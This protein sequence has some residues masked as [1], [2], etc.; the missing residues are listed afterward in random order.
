MKCAGS[1]CGP[2]KSEHA[3]RGATI[4]LLSPQRI[5]TVGTQLGLRGTTSFKQGNDSSTLIKLSYISDMD[6]LEDKAEREKLTISITLATV[7]LQH[8]R[9][10]GPSTL[11]RH[12]DDILRILQHVATL[13]TT[14]TARNS[15][16]RKNDPNASRVVAVTA[17]VQDDAIRALLVT[18]N[19]KRGS[20]PGPTQETEIR[21]LGTKKA[22][23]E[24]LDR[25]YERECVLSNALIPIPHSRHM[26]NHC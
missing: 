8:H 25:W 24:V 16:D 4:F 6:S 20:S 26:L 12:N 5:L 23:G 10:S 9:V 19:T 7:A 15:P 18:T 14:G 13:I 3:S 22:G 2:R 11:E 17:N 1:F 21:S